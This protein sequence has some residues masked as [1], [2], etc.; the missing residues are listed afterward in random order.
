M[1]S[2]RGQTAREMNPGAALMAKDIFTRGLD[3]LPDEMI[4]EGARAQYATCE[5]SRHHLASLTWELEAS[6]RWTSFLDLARKFLKE[7]HA[8][9]ER[10]LLI[11]EQTC[12]NRG[13]QDI[14]ED[15]PY[16]EYAA[17]EETLTLSVL[18]EQARQLK[19][20]VEERGVDDLSDDSY[21]EPGYYVRRLNTHHDVAMLYTLFYI[22][23]VI[24]IM[25]RPS[26]LTSHVDHDQALFTTIMP[27]KA[28]QAPKKPRRKQPQNS[29]QVQRPARGS[30]ENPCLN[31]D[32]SQ[33][34]RPSEQTNDPTL[35]DD[36]LLST[37]YEE[38]MYLSDEDE[39][40]SSRLCDDQ[41][42]MEYQQPPVR[43]A[44]PHYSM[45]GQSSN[46][47]LQH[48]QPYQQLPVHQPQGG[49][50]FQCSIDAPPPP[51]VRGAERL[52]GRLRDEQTRP[53]RTSPYPLPGL[54][55]V[56]VF[57]PRR[58]DEGYRDQWQ[59][60]G[61]I[62]AGADKNVAPKRPTARDLPPIPLP[63][64]DITVPGPQQPTLP[65]SHPIQSSNATHSHNDTGS[66]DAV[67]P[68]Q[69]EP[70]PVP[71]DLVNEISNSARSKMRRS[72]LSDNGMPTNEEN[73]AMARA[74]L[75][76]AIATHATIPP[77]RY[78][79]PDE[80]KFITSLTKITNTL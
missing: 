46:P 53:M 48:Q 2:L 15:R 43:Q 3:D 74:A 47:H 63:P 7:K 14:Y 55:K 8:Y 62:Y 25:A 12:T 68:Q 37:M 20:Y 54:R 73:I 60:T 49:H 28:M 50:M 45:L 6:S 64:L 23:I 22:V 80:D 24:A 18:Q 5:I 72:V 21:L 42:P 29:R 71:A 11:W 51:T 33:V 32:E 39:R 67:P 10:D 75:S 41:Q 35:V 17:T 19:Q 76:N 16:H 40:L 78:Y 26:V 4:R 77:G 58:I 56:S 61:V 79:L 44:H 27:P 57:G 36:R 1:K 34:G 66:S 52:S 38:E 30:N 70:M 65:H 9:S 59:N 69:Q 31:N 13:V